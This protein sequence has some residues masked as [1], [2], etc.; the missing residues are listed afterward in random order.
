MR[1]PDFLRRLHD[2]AVDLAHD[3]GEVTLTHFGSR[4]ADE[5]KVDGSPVTLADREAE[6]LLRRRILEIFPDHGI[7]GEE[8]GEEIGSAPVRWIL[9]PIDGTRSFMRGVPLYGVLI[10][11]EVEGEPVVGV[12]HFP[13]LGETVSAARGQGCRWND[14][15]AAVNDVRDLGRAVALTSDSEMT[16]TS[17]LCP[18]WLDL[19][20]EVDYLRS[21]G[22]A[23]GHVLVATGRAEI[24]VDSVLSPWDAAPLLTILTEAGGRFTDL[25]GG[26]GIHGGSG[27][28]TNG[29]LHEEVLAL[30]RRHSGRN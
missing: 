6:T 24:M 20:S 15:A 26:T 25:E 14:G 19:L 27:L 2:I 16:R 10:G 17:P 22:D 9:D 13:A 7:L 29:H 3:A 4:V 12:A 21:W 28:S 11:I 8:F 1:D 18:G 5:S 23:Y 30:I